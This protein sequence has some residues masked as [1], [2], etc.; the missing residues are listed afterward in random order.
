M[1]LEASADFE[2]S[3]YGSIFFTHDEQ[4]VTSNGSLFDDAVMESC[5]MNA[6]SYMTEEQC[7]HY[8]GIGYVVK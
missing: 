4:S 5:S 1:V 6:S 3:L 7:V 8:G 2:A